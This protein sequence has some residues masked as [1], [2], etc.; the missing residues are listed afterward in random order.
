[1]Y[2]RKPTVWGH[3]TDPITRPIYSTA[4]HIW[5]VWKQP[6]HPHIGP[7]YFRLA[8]MFHFLQDQDGGVWVGNLRTCHCQSSKIGNNF[9]ELLGLE[10]PSL[11]MNEQI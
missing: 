10:V 3:V 4:Q 6:G 5:L 1:M 9:G 7:V 2:A 11:V 8:R